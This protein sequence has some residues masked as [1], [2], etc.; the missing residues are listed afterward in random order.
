MQYNEA[1]F[2]LEAAGGDVRKALAL[3]ESYS[4]WAGPLPSGM[5]GGGCSSLTNGA[6][7]ADAAAALARRQ[8]EV[9]C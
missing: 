5:N 3:Q 7:S 6:C 2:L 4:N 9:P 1:V 8:V